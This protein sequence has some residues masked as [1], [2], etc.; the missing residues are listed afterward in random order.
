MRFETFH[1]LLL[2]IL[3]LKK[4]GYFYTRHF[5]LVMFLLM[6]QVEVIKS[7]H[8]G[9]NIEIVLFLKLFKMSEFSLCFVI[10]K[11]TNSLHLHVCGCLY[12]FCLK[13][14]KIWAF[15]AENALK[16]AILKLNWFVLCKLEENRAKRA[17][18]CCFRLK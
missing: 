11:T 5:Q 1:Q 16:Y 8:T 13:C 6:F 4:M 2:F 3:V 17:E 18:S 9:V 12:M 15:S 7:S 10:I 14:R